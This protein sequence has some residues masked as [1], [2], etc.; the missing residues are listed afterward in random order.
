[1]STKSQ[2]GISKQSIGSSRLSTATP[3]ISA[4]AEHASGPSQQ[5]IRERAYQ[6][7]DAQTGQHRDATLNWLQAERELN[8]EGGNANMHR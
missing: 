6:I 2:T 3:L 1:M 8:A 7:H 4:S 5:Q